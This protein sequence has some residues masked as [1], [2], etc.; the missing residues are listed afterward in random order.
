MYVLC[1]LLTVFRLCLVASSERVVN[2]L[3]IC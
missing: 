3:W 2:Q 1:A